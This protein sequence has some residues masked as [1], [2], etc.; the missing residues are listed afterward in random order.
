TGHGSPRNRGT[1]KHTGA[2]EREAPVH[3]CGETQGA[4]PKPSWLHGLA[5]Q[6]EAAGPRC[7]TR[8]WRRELIRNTVRRQVLISKQ[9]LVPS[10]LGYKHYRFR[11]PRLRRPRL[12]QLDG[13]MVRPGR[14]R[15]PRVLL[16]VL[17]A[18]HPL[19]GA[20]YLRLDRTDQ[21]A[22]PNVGPHRQPIVPKHADS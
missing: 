9:V 5:A 7:R 17:P 22:R 3:G 14:F 15:W 2:G 13:P 18:D 19:L 10:T 8:C 12:L 20:A 1:A 6:W 11:H 21:R 4:Y 16:P